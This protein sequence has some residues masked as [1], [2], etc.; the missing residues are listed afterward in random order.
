MKETERRTTRVTVRPEGNA[1]I[2]AI[3]GKKKK[4]CSRLEGATNVDI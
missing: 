3:L 1:N 2:L 4:K